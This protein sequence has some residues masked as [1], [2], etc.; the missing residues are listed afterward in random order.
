MA[1]FCQTGRELYHY[2]FSGTPPSAP[3]VEN[4]DDPMGA[5]PAPATTDASAEKYSLFNGQEVTVFSKMVDECIDIPKSF[6]DPH[7][8]S[9]PEIQGSENRLHPLTIQPPTRPSFASLVQH[10]HEQLDSYLLKQQEAGMLNAFVT[11][12]VGLLTIRTPDMLSTPTWLAAIPPLTEICMLITPPFTSPVAPDSRGQGL[13]NG[14]LSWFSSLLPSSDL[15]YLFSLAFCWGLMP[16][17]KSSATYLTLTALWCCS[18]PPETLPARV[19]FTIQD[20]LLNLLSNFLSAAQ[21]HRSGAIHLTM[22]NNW[23]PPLSTPM[24]GIPHPIE[25]GLLT[26]PHPPSRLISIFPSF[27]LL[28]MV[29]CLIR[30]LTSSLRFCNSPP[31]FVLVVS[32][33]MDKISP[34][35][36]DSVPTAAALLSMLS[37]IQGEVL[38]SS[39][40]PECSFVTL[41]RS[42]R[43]GSLPLPAGYIH[44]LAFLRLH[45]KFLAP[46]SP[47][48]LVA[49]PALLHLSLKLTQLLLGHEPA[50]HWAAMF[51]SI[52]TPVFCLPHFL[53]G[54]RL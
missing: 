41:L 24:P 8:L 28:T 6:E 25:N 13:R 47:L 33:P 49:I 37:A 35:L 23:S 31:S 27:V 46:S 7:R 3:T 22:C 21:T 12:I 18:P 42:H 1:G 15:T 39:P 16:P 53:G 14:A 11:F 20:G 4:L 48:S 38:R 9:A 26:W 51:A 5:S 34:Q 54:P 19:F 10:L 36:G 45:L 2:L 17:W 52:S 29:L 44:R 50:S 40:A 30:K 32:P 43:T